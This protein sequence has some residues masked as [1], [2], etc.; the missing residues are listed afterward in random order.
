MM[1]VDNPHGAPG[2]Q[3]G[4]SNIEFHFIW[5]TD[6]LAPAHFWKLIKRLYVFLSG[7]IHH[8]VTKGTKNLDYSNM[9]SFVPLVFLV[10]ECDPG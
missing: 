9:L 7:G 5:A 1:L 2:F 3:T 4:G 10:V 8:Q 6:P